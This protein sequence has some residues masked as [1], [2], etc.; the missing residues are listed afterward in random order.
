[1]KLIRFRIFKSIISKIN[2]LNQ[3]IGKIKYDE[4][5]LR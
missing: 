1:M 2:K 4:K 5:N 3:I